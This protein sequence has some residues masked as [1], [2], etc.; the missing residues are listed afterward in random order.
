MTS[1]ED[2]LEDKADD[3]PRDVVDSAGGRNGTSS[4]EDDR[5]VDVAEPAVGPFQAEEVGNNGAENTNEE[6]EYEP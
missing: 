3:G 5:E 1:A 2:V 6:E 4:V